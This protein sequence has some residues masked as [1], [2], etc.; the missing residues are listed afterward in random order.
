VLSAYY[1]PAQIRE[2]QAEKKN[3]SEVQTSEA[4]I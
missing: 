3:A 4:L 2:M 1:G